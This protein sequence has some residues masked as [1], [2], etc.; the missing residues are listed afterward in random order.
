MIHMVNPNKRPP[1]GFA[2]Y[3][4][5]FC[6]YPGCLLASGLSYIRDF[7]ASLSDRPSRQSEVMKL[8]GAQWRTMSESEKAVSWLHS[9]MTVSLIAWCGF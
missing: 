9:Y 2:R 4:F 5:S 6:M 7:Q 8:A 3:V 1:N